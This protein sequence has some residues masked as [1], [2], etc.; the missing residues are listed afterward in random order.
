[1]S[2]IVTPCFFVQT[3]LPVST[4]FDGHTSSD[5]KGQ[6]EVHGFPLF[7]GIFSVEYPVA[8]VPVKW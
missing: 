4:P 8:T 7:Y 2:S 5:Y 6:F 3:W 1:M